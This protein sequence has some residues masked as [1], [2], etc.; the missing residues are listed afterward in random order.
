[1]SPHSLPQ[2][3]RHSLPRWR[4]SGAQRASR[5]QAAASATAAKVQKKKAETEEDREVVPLL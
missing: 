2:T 3:P 5:Q 1:M 4:G